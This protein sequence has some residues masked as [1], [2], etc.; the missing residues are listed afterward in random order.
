MSA[1]VSKVTK[2]RSGVLDVLRGSPIMGPFAALVLAMYLLCH[3]KR[4]VPDRREFL[5]DHAA[6]DGG[7]YPGDRANAGHPDRRNRSVQR[8]DHGAGLGAHD[9]ARRAI[10][11]ES[12][13]GDPGGY[14]GGRASL[15]C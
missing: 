3:A 8:H 14:P 12:A 9:R 5:P 15:A 2:R 7:R 6:G 10:R 13:S 1:V 11:A 4:Q